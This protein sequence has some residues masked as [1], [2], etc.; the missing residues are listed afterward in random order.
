MLLRLNYAW[1][2]LTDSIARTTLGHLNPTSGNDIMHIISLRKYSSSIE[3]TPDIKQIVLTSVI[4]AGAR[5]LQIGKQEG[6]LK[7]EGY[8]AA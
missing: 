1:W 3:I 7:S 4:I 6:N 5:S 2:Q 8:R